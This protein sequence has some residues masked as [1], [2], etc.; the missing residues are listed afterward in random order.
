MTSRSGS[1]PS[2]KVLGAT[3][4][5]PTSSVLRVMPSGVSFP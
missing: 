5:P 3:L 2:T 1:I 4:V